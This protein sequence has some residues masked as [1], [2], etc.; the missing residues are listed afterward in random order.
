ME[1]LLAAGLQEDCPLPNLGSAP[2]QELSPEAAEGISTEAFAEY[3]GR[4]NQYLQV[5]GAHNPAVGPP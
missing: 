1:N 5:Q 4:L 3:A 2:N